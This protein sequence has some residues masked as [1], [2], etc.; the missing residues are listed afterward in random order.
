MQAETQLQSIARVNGVALNTADTV[1][2]GDELRQRAYSELLRQ[3]LSIQE[4]L[5][6]AILLGFMMFKPRGL[7]AD[8]KKRIARNPA[9]QAEGMQRGGTA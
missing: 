7:F 3:A 1:L 8:T 5:Y 4:I 6:G 2:S 9:V